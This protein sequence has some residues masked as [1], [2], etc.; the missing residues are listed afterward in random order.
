[1]SGAT[2]EL[3]AP[4]AAIARRAGRAI[5]EIYAGGELASSA[6]ADASP[7]TAADLRAHRLIL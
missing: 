7:I 1:M 2:H 3:L 4:V 5:L 6:K